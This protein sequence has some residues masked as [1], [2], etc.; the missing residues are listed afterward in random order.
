MTDRPK[1]R[2][3]YVGKLYEGGCHVGTFQHTHPGRYHGDLLL[4][5][6]SAAHAEREEAR[7]A[8]DAIVKALPPEWARRVDDAYNRLISDEWSWALSHV[9]DPF[10]R[11]IGRC[12]VIYLEQDEAIPEFRADSTQNSRTPAPLTDRTR[13]RVWRIAA[14]LAAAL[15]AGT[16]IGRGWRR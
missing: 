15:A 13:R 3:D 2:V 5:K 8:M 7:D 16:L 14:G 12:S 9:L 1:N 10:M 11:D 4:R 6:P